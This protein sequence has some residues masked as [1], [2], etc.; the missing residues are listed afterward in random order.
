MDTSMS[1]PMDLDTNSADEIVLADYEELCSSEEKPVLFSSVDPEVAM[2]NRFTV[3]RSSACQ[4]SL[5]TPLF[6]C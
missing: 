1:D 3:S 4:A 2:K 5:W 6:V